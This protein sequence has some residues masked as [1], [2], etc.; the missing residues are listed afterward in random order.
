MGTTAA[1]GA[2]RHLDAEVTIGQEAARRQGA[3]VRQS[4]CTSTLRLLL[5]PL[6]SA[7]LPLPPGP[8]PPQSLGC[9]TAP[10]YVPSRPARAPQ[11][12]M[13]TALGSLMGSTKFIKCSCCS[14]ISLQITHNQSKSEPMPVVTYLIA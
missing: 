9:S 4:P 8:S 7:P 11:T 13:N 3:A 6:S 1:V 5:C 12:S 2:E 10:N 14:R